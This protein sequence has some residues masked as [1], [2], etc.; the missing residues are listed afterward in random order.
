MALG[1]TCSPMF[2][3]TALRVDDEEPLYDDFDHILDE[4]NAPS[5]GDW[6][7]IARC[8]TRGRAGSVARNSRTK[9]CADAVDTC[10]K[11]KSLSEQKRT[12]GAA[13]RAR[14]CEISEVFTNR[15]TVLLAHQGSKGSKHQQRTRNQLPGRNTSVVP[16]ACF[17]SPDEEQ[18]AQ[19]M[20][21]DIATYRMLRQ[22]EQRDICP[23]DYDLLGRLDETVKHTTLS[24]KD[25]L[26]FPTQTYVA[27]TAVVCSMI[28]DNIL[29]DISSSVVSFGVDFW[30]L[31]LFCSGEE[32]HNRTCD[33]STCGSVIHESCTVCLSD[34][35]E[36]DLLRVLPCSHRFHQHCIDQWLLHSSTACPACKVDLRQ[37]SHR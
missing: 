2:S 8:K 17:F 10:C 1:S 32:H 29:R 3:L 5:S 12:T 19:G 6:D 30:K 23:E 22:L 13:R 36:G 35:E 27:P 37:E 34:L 11:I 15:P 4:Y 21:L 14:R 16:R 18:L 9:R 33:C 26:R 20:G 31:P 7:C 24:V 28:T 25:L